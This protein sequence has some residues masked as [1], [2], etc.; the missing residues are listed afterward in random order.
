MEHRS[1]THSVITNLTGLHMVQAD[2]TKTREV[3]VVKEC[4]VKDRWVVDPV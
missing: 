3:P 2:T 4:S 1:L